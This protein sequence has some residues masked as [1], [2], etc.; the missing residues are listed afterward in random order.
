[1]LFYQIDDKSIIKKVQEII[2]KL[3]H[4]GS[5]LSYF[6]TKKNHFY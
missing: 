3:T 5:K 1:M 2:N 6:T 4:S